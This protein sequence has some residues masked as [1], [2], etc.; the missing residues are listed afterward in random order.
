M[1]QL[2]LLLAC[3]LAAP[4]SAQSLVI[5]RVDGSDVTLDAARLSTLPQ[6]SFEG[7]NLARADLSRSDLTRGIFERAEAGAANFA[8]AVLTDADFSSARLEAADFH[9]AD[10]SRANLHAVADRDAKWNGATLKQVRK[11]DKDRLYAET[12][13]CPE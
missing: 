10:L 11:T 3:L 8:E 7:A 6:S 12:W 5:R 2:A 9:K 13:T 4:L 1:R